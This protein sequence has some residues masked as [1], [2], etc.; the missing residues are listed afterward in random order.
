LNREDIA[1]AVDF[2]LPSERVIR[3]LRVVVK[4]ILERLAAQVQNFTTQ[5]M[6]SYNHNLPNMVLGKLTQKS[7]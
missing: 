2:Y 3:E 6:W 5:W 1:I 7:D 4:V